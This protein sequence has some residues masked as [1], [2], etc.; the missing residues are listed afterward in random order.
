LKIWFLVH[1]VV[2]ILFALPLMIAPQRFLSVLGWS[3]IDPILSRLVAAA[4]FGIGIESLLS[5]KAPLSTY[6]G[7]LNLKIIWS[8]AAIIG[9]LVSLAASGAGATRLAWAVAG[10]FLVFDIVWIYWRIRVDE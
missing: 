4:L 3:A 10:I 5:V 2:D 6:I 9:I 8:S 7:M 1:F